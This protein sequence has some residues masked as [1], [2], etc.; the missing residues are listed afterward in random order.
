MLCIAENVAQQWKICW[1]AQDTGIHSDDKRK[2]KEFMYH[3]IPDLFA[4]QR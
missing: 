4:A 2:M 3:F 1:E